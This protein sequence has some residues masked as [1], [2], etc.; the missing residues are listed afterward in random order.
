MN[1]IKYSE[2]SDP[3]SLRVGN[4]N[5]GDVSKAPTEITG[6]WTGITPPQGGYTIYLNKESNG[7]SIYVCQNDS[8]LISLTKRISFEN[9]ND[10]I[11][12][13]NWLNSQLDSIVA[14]VQTVGDQ[15][16]NFN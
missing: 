14:T 8:E 1:G 5:I 9:I 2:S 6:Y 11:D 15:F 12:A 13:I 7:P 4:F 16:N 10:A 3:E